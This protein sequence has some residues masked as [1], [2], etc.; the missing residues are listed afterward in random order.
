[1]YYISIHKT[2]RNS[3]VIH[4]TF[5]SIFSFKTFFF[6]FQTTCCA[7]PPVFLYS[8]KNAQRKYIDQKGGTQLSR[9]QLVIIYIVSTIQMWNKRHV[10]RLMVEFSFIKKLGKYNL[11]EERRSVWVV[12]LLRTSL[13]IF[14][15]Y[16]MYVCISGV[17]IY[18]STL[19]NENRDIFTCICFQ[20]FHFLVLVKYFRMKFTD[21]FSKF[22]AKI[23]NDKQIILRIDLPLLLVS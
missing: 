8:Q 18:F 16:P 19:I 17:Y 3:N 22:I 12:P 13:L 21:I 5:L 2:L 6:F 9:E 23:Q 15:V 10:Y 7:I 11:S 4:L 20:P 1:M 14:Y